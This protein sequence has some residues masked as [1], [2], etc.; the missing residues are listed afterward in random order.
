MWV[1]FNVGR[2]ALPGPVLALLLALVALLGTALPSRAQ[3]AGSADAVAPAAGTAINTVISTDITQNTTWTKAGSP[4][5]VTQFVSVRPGVTLTI[6]PGVQVVFNNNVPFG[7]QGSLVA[8]GTAAEPI[9]FTGATKQAGSWG[10]IT[11]NN[12]RGQTPAVVKFDYVTVEYGVMVGLFNRGNLELD[13]AQAEID[14][15]TFRFGGDHG[16][17]AY[18][19]AVTLKNSTFTNNTT[20]AV[21]FNGGDGPD[22]VLSNLSA[23]GNGQYNAVVYYAYKLAQA[24]TLEKMGL[25]YVF[26]SGYEVTETGSLTIQPGVQVRVD[27]GFSVYGGKLAALGT[28]AEPILFTGL[29]QQPGGWWG[30]RVAMGAND[31]LANATLDHMVIE[32][33][34]SNTPGYGGNLVVTSSNVTVTNSVLR[35]SNVYGLYNSGGAPGET[36][37]VKLDNVSITGN[38]TGA[39]ICTDET[40]N[41]SLHNLQVSGNGSNTYAIKAGYTADA[42]WNY[43]GIPYEIIGQGGVFNQAK[44]TIEPGV[45][46]RMGQDASFTVNGALFAVG[47]PGRPIT[48]TATTQQA[49]GWQGF[50]IAPTAYAEL[51]YCDIGYGGNWGF[52][53]NGVG[54]V[55]TRSSSTYITNCRIHDSST[56]G[57]VVAADAQ[58]QIDHNRIESN[59]VG[60]DAS[61]AMKQVDARNNWWGDASGPAHANNPGGRGQSITGDVLFNPWLQSPDDQGGLAPGLTVELNGPGR[62]APGD[63][64]V[65]SVF[66]RNGLGQAIDNAVLRFGMPNSAQLLEIGRGGQFWSERNQVYWKLGTLANGAQGIVY[67]RVRYDWGLSDGMKSTTAAQLSGTNLA[68][69]VFDVTPYLSYAPR[70]LAASTDISEAQVQALRGTSPSFDELYRQVTAAGFKFGAAEQNSYSG[71]QSEL[72]VTLLRFSPQFNIFYLWLAGGKGVG[73]LVDG[74][75]YTVFRSGSALRYDLQTNAWARVT[76]GIVQSAEFTWSDCMQNCIEEKI[77]GYIVKKNIKALSEISKAVSCVKAASG[78]E[79][80]VLGCAKYIGKIVP[81]VGEGIDLGQCNLDCQ[82]CEAQGGN[83]DNPLC[84]CCTE[85]SYRCDGSDWLYGTFGIDVIK[86]RKCNVDDPEEGIGKYLAETVVKVCALCEKCI[87]NGSQMACVAKNAAGFELANTFQQVVTLAA[88]AGA[89]TQLQAEVNADLECEDCKIAKDP[90]EM[91]GPAGDLLPGQ[92][93][94]YTIAYENVGAGEAHDVF[95][96]DKLPDEFDPAT[97]Q[98]GNGGSYSAG[99]KSIFW[100]VGTLQPKGQ[101][102][103]KGTVSFSVRLRSGLPS[104]TVIANQ[105]V[106]HFPSVPEETPTNRVVNVIQPLVAEPQKLETAAGQPIAV[107]LAGRDAAGAPLSY[108]I[109]EGPF[110]GSITGAAP[111]LQYVPESGAGRLDRIRFTVSNG[112]STSA[113]ADVTIHILPSP[114]DVTGPS[115]VWTGPTDKAEVRLAALVAGTDNTGSY[116]YPAIQAQLSEPADPATV[117]GQTVIVTDASGG[118]IPADVRYDGATDQVQVLMRQA[119]QV[120]AAYAVTLS[121]VRDLRGN[122]MAVSYTWSFRIVG[123]GAV[124]GGQNLYL[125]LVKR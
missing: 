22:A 56:A 17:Y 40:C 103:S 113:A 41:M 28:A 95:I 36:F 109:V 18:D 63:S 34:G 64:V 20:S 35:N 37:A 72:K 87:N 107:T 9:L 51:R 60:L 91:Y 53:G 27:N 4:Y 89:R 1:C 6:E 67:V 97:L 66:Y 50:S 69:P 90:N 96:V 114:N 7:V 57:L 110:Y 14:H 25:P 85:D 39:I 122:G 26:K 104:G 58:P 84:H 52:N 105:A 13:Y 117:N 116:Y 94:A 115:V 43:L 119:P 76:S 71:G 29:N 99:A 12:G 68:A 86:M 112:A 98:I 80:S 31:E 118:V 125:P 33:G 11:A 32:Y 49:G 38:Q 120:G 5:Q 82:T 88:Q 46:V 79:S 81:G 45:E 78:D 100:T 16:L 74:S 2:K 73:A 62:F 108:A 42:A 101:E 111:N 75:S 106:V 47:E 19:S 65:Y 44:L 61:L 24:H 3:D 77:P 48:F 54:M 59:A 10:G 55:T 83:C 123:I 93:V 124:D 15:S 23:G 70:T 102:G 21:V 92:L 121:G 30:L 8:I